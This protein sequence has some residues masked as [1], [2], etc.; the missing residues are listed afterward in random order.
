LEP[1]PL[2]AA[3]QHVGLP[4]RNRV[5][6]FLRSFRVG[7][8]ARRQ[9]PSLARRSPP[10]RCESVT[11]TWRP[12]PL[13]ASSSSFAATVAP[14]VRIMP[15]MAVARAALLRVF[16]SRGKRQPRPKPR[17]GGGGPLLYSNY[18]TQIWKPFLE[19]LG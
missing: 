4:P 11:R 3:E 10:A 9:A 1:A 6:R 12:F 15:V 2:L 14:S 19:R 8:A 18:R 17:E 7:G 13:I 5:R 16:P